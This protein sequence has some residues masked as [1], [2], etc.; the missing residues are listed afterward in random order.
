MSDITQVVTFLMC[1]LGLK[2]DIYFR[3]CFILAERCGGIMRSS[4]KSIALICLMPVLVYAKTPKGK[5]HA[6]NDADLSEMGSS[7]VEHN[8]LL[9]LSDIKPVHSEQKEQKEQKEP[10]VQSPEMQNA[11][12]EVRGPDAVGGIIP[13]ASPLATALGLRSGALLPSGLHEKI[14]Q[15]Q[16][17]MD[18][19]TQARK[20]MMDEAIAKTSEAMIQE[21]IGPVR[22]QKSKNQINDKII[23]FSGR[24]IP[25]MKTG[26]LI[27]DPEGNYNLTIT[28]NVNTKTLESMLKDNG[29]LYE[30]EATPLILPVVSFVDK[31]QDRSFRW[32][33][34]ATP[35]NPDLLQQNVQIQYLNL[36][37][38]LQQNFMD[39]GFYLERPEASALSFLQTNQRNKDSL[40]NED[41]VQLSNLFKAS[42][43]IDGEVR[44]VPGVNSGEVQLEIQMSARQVTTGRVLAELYRK[45]TWDQSTVDIWA[46]K[47]VHQ[48]V[49]GTLKDLSQQVKD[50]WQKGTFSSSVLRLVVRGGLPLSRYQKFKEQ[51][52]SQSK[53]IRQIRERIIGTD[54]IIFEIDVNGSIAEISNQLQQVNLEDLH[55]QLAAQDT[56]SLTLVG[57][58]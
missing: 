55:F 1:D 14:Y 22:F 50:A 38:L 43:I 28:M 45:S 4:L 12:H 47:K 48:W 51:I 39:Q 40:S 33:K 44:V 58:K 42:A 30:T 37:K 9:D 52:Q 7:G 20:K 35:G 11:T 17:K 6:Q 46:Q 25:V 24:F 5:L 3:N 27:K 29:L 13:V 16:V 31:I 34:S 19:P 8:E 53:S 23:K 18:S 41:W 32:W 56:Q 2:L 49:D 15:A 10:P 57:R 26:D 36:E 54:E 21:I